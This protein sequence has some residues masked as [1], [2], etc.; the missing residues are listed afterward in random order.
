M[1][2]KT[3]LLSIIITM[4]LTL[5]AQNSKQCKLWIFCPSSTTICSNNQNYQLIESANGN[6]EGGIK[7]VKDKKG[8]WVL[9]KQN[10]TV[11]ETK[12]SWFKKLFGSNSVKPKK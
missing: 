4:T 5:E 7:F 1:K 11:P 9:K 10:Q 6:L 3:F 8:C 2:S 12:V